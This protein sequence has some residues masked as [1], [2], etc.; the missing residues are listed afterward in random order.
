MKTDSVGL[1]MQPKSSQG[2]PGAPRSWKMPETSST[3]AFEGHAA[4]TSPQLRFLA[5]QTVSEQISVFVR[6]PVCANLLW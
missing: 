3:K 5:F 4:L 1:M 6:Y 2:A